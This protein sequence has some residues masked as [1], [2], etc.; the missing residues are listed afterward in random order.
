MFFR[1]RIP[2]PQKGRSYL[3]LVSTCKYFEKA[4]EGELS[5]VLVLLL[6]RNISCVFVVLLAYMH[7]LFEL[8]IFA[9]LNS[10]VF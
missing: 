8:C 10:V 4:E 9:D 7:L 6:N 5:C 1:V 2:N 3:R